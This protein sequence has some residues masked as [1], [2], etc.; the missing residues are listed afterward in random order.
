METG[1]S[2]DALFARMGQILT[3]RATELG[4]S[5][6]KIEEESSVSR[7]SV[8]RILAGSPTASANKI[9]DVAHALGLRAWK[10]MAQAERELAEA[11][12]ARSVEEIDPVQYVQETE[13]KL[14]SITD[15]EIGL[16]AHGQKRDQLQFDEYAE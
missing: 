1:S 3:D 16:A 6:R 10:V 11:R 14:A 9:I 2:S 5:L 15:F 7:M 4:W 12:A 13:A 8:Q